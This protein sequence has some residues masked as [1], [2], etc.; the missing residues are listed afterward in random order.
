MSRDQEI[1]LAV[2][3][4]GTFVDAVELDMATGA[5]RFEK[6][7][8]TPQGPW[9]GV[10]N[11]LARLRDDLS[12]AS[13][14]THG[15][16]L[17]LNAILER[18]G[19]LTGIITNKG[20]R[21][22]FLIGRGNVPDAHMYDFRYERPEPL[23]KRRRIAGVTCRLD[24]KGRELEPLAEDE[25]REA[26]R[27]LVEEQ[28]IETIAIAY[29]FS[30]R[31]PRHEQRTAEIV[32]EMYPDVKVSVSS[33]ITREQ[34]EY[35]RTST[36]VLDAYIRPIFERYI[37]RLETELR[38][39]AFA[40]RFNIMRSGGGAM[41]AGAA[42]LSPTQTV[43]SGPAG[44]VVGGAFIAEV[45]KRPDLVTFDV[46]GTSLDVCVIEQTVP[47]I[48]HE[49]E[50][51]NHPLLVPCYDIRTIGAGGGSIASMDAGLLKVGPR[52]AGAEPGPIC[53]GRGG[54][55][56][57]VTDAAVLLGFVDPERFLGGRMPL[58]A[59]AAEKGIEAN[60]G[61]AL[62]LAAIEAAARIY[63]V[64][65]ARTVGA[66]RQL[67]VERGR[68]PGDFSLLGFGGA[69][70]LI[71]PLV[72]REMG[73]RETIVPLLPSGFSAWGMLGA[74]IVND[75]A[76]T[77]L[78]VLSDVAPEALDE[79]FRGME[80]DARTSLQAQGIGEQDALTE[81]QLEL[82]YLGQ[83]HGLT[84]PVGRPLDIDAITEAFGVAHESRYGHR[85]DS[86]VQILNVRV[87]GIGRTRRPT[88]S[89]AAPAEAA[90][91]AAPRAQ[92]DAYCF[93][94]RALT[95]FAAYDRGH[96]PAGSRI[97]G[98]ALVDE[99]TSVTVIHSDQALEVNA[100]GH[101]VITRSGEGARHER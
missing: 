26:A 21:D 52:S 51:E 65:L 97:A 25:V 31:D 12:A 89:E 37:D 8:T 85:M 38:E 92:R 40:G 30:F 91:A 67:T 87:R 47:Q 59:A 10:M 79:R 1:R 9:E 11:A 84:L 55:E 7:S 50:L 53:Y 74:D 27:M 100:F 15:T 17:G 19:A 83:E 90:Q 34:R 78:S 24:Y 20:F 29:L 2:D 81:R 35:E 4:G 86:P 82:R 48:T 96:L 93:A 16:T 58:D 45:L 39:R 49:A 36:T 63:D 70:P 101:L 33:D 23:V 94:R 57:T 80:D 28:G 5:A 18:K 13:V 64:M 3:I 62:G 54:T 14:F 32:R 72:A 99:G 95:S 71:A 44:G 43:L 73:L 77:D 56:P 66:V 41:T 88:V 42:K 69:G 46:G 68:D 76:Q 60:I 22:I 98:P 75:F 61:A 6:A